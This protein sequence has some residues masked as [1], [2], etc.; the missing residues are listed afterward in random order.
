[1]RHIYVIP[2]VEI[3]SILQDNAIQAITLINDYDEEKKESVLT[4]LGEDESRNMKLKN[5]LMVKGTI[6]E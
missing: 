5:P 6:V 4:V 2:A 1:M 3:K